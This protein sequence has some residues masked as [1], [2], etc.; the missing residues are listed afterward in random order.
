MSTTID[1]F[2]CP[3]CGCQAHRDQDNRTGEVYFGCADCDWHG[4]PIPYE[5]TNND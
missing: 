3:K 5:G 4:E 2:D 1:W